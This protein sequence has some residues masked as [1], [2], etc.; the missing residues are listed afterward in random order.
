MSAMLKDVPPGWERKNFQAV[1]HIRVVANA[2]VA[3]E[4]MTSECW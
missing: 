1:L 3:V 4:L 2:P